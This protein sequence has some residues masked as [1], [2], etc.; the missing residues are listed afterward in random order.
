MKKKPTSPIKRVDPVVCALNTMMYGMLVHFG[1]IWAIEQ[2]IDD[3]HQFN[4]H[5]SSEAFASPPTMPLLLLLHEHWVFLQHANVLSNPHLQHLDRQYGIALLKNNQHWA[6]AGTLSS[7]W[8]RESIGM[9]LTLPYLHQIGNAQGVPYAFSKTQYLILYSLIY[10]T[11]KSRGVRSDAMRRYSNTFGIMRLV[12]DHFF[13][14]SVEELGVTLFRLFLQGLDTYIHFNIVRDLMLSIKIVGSDFMSSIHILFVVWV[15]HAALNQLFRCS[16]ASVIVQYWQWLTAKPPQRQSPNTADEQVKVTTEIRFRQQSSPTEDPVPDICKISKFERVPSSCSS[17]LSSVD[18]F[19]D[20][21]NAN[22][23]KYL[24]RDLLD[25][26][27]VPH[28]LRGRQGSASSCVDK[29]VRVETTIA[30]LTTFYMIGLGDVPF[31]VLSSKFSMVSSSECTY[32]EVRRLLQDTQ[33]LCN[34]TLFSWL[35]WGVLYGI[36]ATLLRSRRPDQA[37]GNHRHHSNR[38]RIFMCAFDMSVMIACGKRLMAPK[39]GVLFTCALVTARS[40]SNTHRQSTPRLARRTILMLEFTA[41]I[42]ILRALLSSNVVA[43]TLLLPA[44]ILSCIWMIWAISN[45]IPTPCEVVR[46]SSSAAD[47]VFLGHPAELSDS[48]ALWLL[49]YSLEERW[50]APF[51]AV[52]LWPLHYIVGIY[53]CKYRRRLFGDGASFFCC[54]DVR[55]DNIRI[56]NW[57]AAHFARHFVT[58]P[59]QVKTNIE[60]AARH[61]SQKIPLVVY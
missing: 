55:Y 24:V 59:R 16:T 34:V 18:N 54:D 60:A 10:H 48:W 39:S 27:R 3:Q 57:V 45:P 14:D 61:V 25:H 51:W 1:T 35:F 15:I 21:F 23:K 56:Q 38:R 32:V 44:Y 47:A 53:V 28:C 20:Q 26:E 11:I 50:R 4:S 42:S 43:D 46:D 5:T 49:P 17:S 31:R 37:M 36:W 19:T 13:V 58:H 6:I 30:I 12:I 9:F 40:F 29:A 41:K 22:D 2:F 33:C 8:C 7:Y 52:L